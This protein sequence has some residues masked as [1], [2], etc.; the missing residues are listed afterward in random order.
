M[1]NV[2]RV[3]FSNSVS[4]KKSGPTF[5]KNGHEEKFSLSHE[6]V[7]LSVGKLHSNKHISTIKDQWTYCSRNDFYALK[8]IF[9]NPYK[10]IKALFSLQAKTICF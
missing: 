6:T 1:E 4:F 5:A 2:T 9:V 8:H 3:I 7:Y 10:A